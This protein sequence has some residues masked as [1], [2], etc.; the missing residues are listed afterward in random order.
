MTIQ[1]LNRLGY[2]NSLITGIQD[3]CIFTI[4]ISSLAHMIDSA[5]YEEGQVGQCSFLL[6]PLLKLIPEPFFFFFLWA[7]A[8]F[9][10]FDSKSPFDIYYSQHLICFQ[11]KKVLLRVHWTTEFHQAMETQS[12]NPY[13]DLVYHSFNLRVISI[14]CMTSEPSSVSNN[15]VANSVVSNTVE[16]SVL[17]I[18]Y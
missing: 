9:F 6:L 18:F 11:L 13:C 17:S 1:R 2:Q 14:F 8:F 3:I 10:S 4:Y 12:W 7:A 16:T 5:I 15:T